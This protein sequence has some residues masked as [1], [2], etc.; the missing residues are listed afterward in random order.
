MEEVSREELTVDEMK[1]PISI[2]Y[3]VCENCMQIGE[4]DGLDI[5]ICMVASTTNADF[6]YKGMGPS[7]K[8]I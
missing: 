3:R 4:E 2:F 7:W 8:A 6:L 1:S 5:L